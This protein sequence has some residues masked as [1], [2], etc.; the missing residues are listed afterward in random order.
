[1]KKVNKVTLA[2]GAGLLLSIGGM[3]V[4]SWVTS[5]ENEKAMKKFVDERLT[6]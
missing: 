1:M 2:K 4:T 6:K 5:K 3:I